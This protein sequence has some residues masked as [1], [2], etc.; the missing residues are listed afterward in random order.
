LVRLPIAEIVRSKK[1]IIGQ[2]IDVDRFGNLITNIKADDVA[3][4][5]ESC[6]VEVGSLQIDEIARCYADVE[7]S[8]PIALFGSSGRL[9]IS[10]RN[11]NAADEL[12]L[13]C[14]RQVVVR[15]S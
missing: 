13:D 7:M 5:V 8:E 11:G 9:E 1:S 15:W 3:D 12:N 2:V 4:Q 14:G 10:I 6:R